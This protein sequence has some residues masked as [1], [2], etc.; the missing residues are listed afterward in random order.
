MGAT[1][2]VNG[3]ISDERHAVIPVFDHGFLYGEGVYETIRT[4]GGRPFLLDRHL[5]RLR[6]S[7]SLIALPVPLSDDELAA[8]IGETIAAASV[9]GP[10]TEWYI[11]I[12]LTRG[13]GELTYDPTACPAPTAV[14]IVK[15]HVDPS[16]ELFTNG[17]RVIISSVV[18]NHPDTVNPLIKSN[19]LLNCA[20]AMQEGFRRGAYEVVM[21]NYKGDLAECALS[22]L[23][24]VKNGGAITPPLSDGLLAGITREFLWEVGAAAG[25]PVTEATLRDQDLYGADEAF[26]TGTTREILPIVVVDDRPIGDGHPGPVTQTLLN[27]F[28]SMVTR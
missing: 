28:R 2:N 1:V 3:A 4:Y 6:T 5:R 19:N 25:I 11:R 21:R 8:R 13:V 18:R 14:V 26:M 24:I 23:F 15:P 16:P 17:V 7:A 22:N 20:L 27:T 9:H 10:A 12:L